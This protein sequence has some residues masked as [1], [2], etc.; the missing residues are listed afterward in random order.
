MERQEE[1]NL[2]DPIVKPEG[3][4][5]GDNLILNPKPI[6]EHLPNMQFKKMVGRDEFEID[7]EGEPK[8]G[9][10]L[11][12]NPTKPEKHVP[13]VDFKK[14]EGRPQGPQYDA[15]SPGPEGDVLIINPKPIEKHIANVDF[16]RQAERENINIEKD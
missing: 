12:L 16:A 8:E 4:S 15:D 13:T 14:Q 3:P 1:K 2:I 10:R 7:R 11:I 9:D 5:D 6:E